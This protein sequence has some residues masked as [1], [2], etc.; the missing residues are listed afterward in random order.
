MTPHLAT[1]VTA[2]T[3][4]LTKHRQFAEADVAELDSTFDLPWNTPDALR[5]CDACVQKHSDTHWIQGF[6]PE[7]LKLYCL[8]SIICS[9]VMFGYDETTSIKTSLN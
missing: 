9:A 3:A 2:V 4:V 5:L 1:R 6:F 8:E 7:F